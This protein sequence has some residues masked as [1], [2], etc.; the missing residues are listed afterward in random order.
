MYKRTLHISSPTKLLKTRKLGD[1]KSNPLHGS[2]SLY[3]SLAGINIPNIPS[4]KNLHLQ[5][6]WRPY[7]SLSAPNL[8]CPNLFG[9]IPTIPNK[10][11]ISK[12]KSSKIN[13]H[14][15]NFPIPFVSQ[16][17]K[18]WTRAN[19]KTIKVL[20]SGCTP[21]RVF[22]RFELVRSQNGTSAALN[23]QQQIY[24]IGSM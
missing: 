15:F 12:W 22:F 24:P 13:D 21:H 3:R 23:N 14:H 1:L 20:D 8:P 18:F 9:N 4:T 11:N 10:Q 17:G 16:L 19:S 2:S 6:P 7:L 5:R